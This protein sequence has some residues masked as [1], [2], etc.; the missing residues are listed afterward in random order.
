[1]QTWLRQG[2]TSDG[3]WVAPSY[4]STLPSTSLLLLPF[5]PLLPLLPLHLPLISWTKEKAGRTLQ[6]STWWGTCHQWPGVTPAGSSTGSVQG[7]PELASAWS[8]T[9]HETGR[10]NKTKVIFLILLF[11]SSPSSFQS[12]SLPTHCQATNS[13]T[14]GPNLTGV[15]FHHSHSMNYVWCWIKKIKWD[16]PGI[17]IWTFWMSVR[18]CNSQRHWSWK[19]ISIDTVLAYQAR[20]SLFFWRVRR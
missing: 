16:L 18:C 11:P 15:Q 4:T 7:S 8:T 9:A 20:P 17:Q 19:Y 6:S 2:R 10:L 3:Q 5:L 13:L 12:S 14:A 1:M